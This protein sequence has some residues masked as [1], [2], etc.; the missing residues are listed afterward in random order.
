MKNDNSNDHLTTQTKGEEKT[1]TEPSAGLDER[2]NFEELFEKSLE[3]REIEE[4]EILDGTVV[5]I[6]SDYVMIDVGYKS[7]GEVPISQFLDQ[8][9]NITV[10]EGDKVAV[11]LERREDEEG[12]IVLSK[13]KADKMRVWDEI[14]KA[15]NENQVIE[16]TVVNKIKGGFTVDIG[17]I[18]AFL[19]G[20]QVALRPVRNLD[21]VIGKKFN[22][23]VLKFNKK[24][25]NIVVSH[26]AFL[27]EERNK[28]RE[29]T[30]K[31]IKEGAILKGKVKNITDYGA[32]IDLGGIDG[33]LHITDISW[34]RINHPTELL[35]VGDEIE[36]KVLNF[37]PNANKVSLGLKQTTP[38]PWDSVEEKYKVGTQ[39]NG[40]IVSITDYGVFVELEKGVEGLVHISEMTWNKKIKHPSKLV[41]LGDIVK[42][43][44]LDLNLEKKR[45][46]L[47]M[48]QIEPNPW[49][50][51]EE[52]YP[53]GTKIIGQ[54][55]TVTDFG[56]FVGVEEGIDG[57]IHTSE[58][59]WTKKIK[60]PQ[61]IFKKGQEIEAI[62]L[63]I[64]KENER[65]SLGIKQ[66]KPDPW[67]TIPDK[68]PVGTLVT[69]KVTSVTDFGAFLEIEDEIE[70]LIHVSEIGDGK[71]KV[72]K[73]SDVISV[74][75]E[76]KAVVINVDPKERKLSL[77][78][79]KAKEMAERAEI[80]KYMNYQ[81]SITSNVGEILKEE[82]NQK[83]GV[84]LK[85]Q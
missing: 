14:N 2:E 26:R 34:G 21:K 6:R 69:G 48:K 45:I 29:R 85:E 79:K 13:E 33:L 30:L 77:S 56:V 65:F 40:K 37:D 1:K 63:K 18:K 3:E 59:S 44:V 52:K 64:D 10:K 49:S 35:S 78:V 81:S 31:N 19:P 46:S 43:V 55:R 61:E 74:G 83:N 16:G 17:G 12:I 28:L 75:D 82:I 54:I 24:R 66:L 39:V 42:V 70:G 76:L 8:N 11:Y 50:I 22:F 7:E 62:V 41:N 47:G 15:Y 53:V 36:V 84:K 5:E 80:E 57:L 71:E 32:F 58:M 51:V 25:E 9:G 27:E 68:Y 4:G 60:N 72:V 20:S 23:K 38:N 67:E 73:P